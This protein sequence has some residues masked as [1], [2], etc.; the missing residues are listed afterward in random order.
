[1]FTP[2][3]R[4]RDPFDDFIE[5]LVLENPDVALLLVESAACAV[6]GACEAMDAAVALDPDEHPIARGAAAVSLLVPVFPSLGRVAS[7]ILRHADDAPNLGRVADDL[8]ISQSADVMRGG[9]GH[10]Y[11]VE[12]LPGGAGP[13]VFAGHGEYRLLSGDVE[14]P[15]GTSLTFWSEHGRGIRDSVGQAIERGE[16]PDGFHEGAV[17]YLPGARIPDYTLTSPRGLTVYE[18]STTVEDATRISDLIRPGMGNC[19][20][21]ACRR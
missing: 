9:S 11:A 16:V 15:E 2:V 18:N 4:P 13:Q 6:P 8:L 1:M 14:I 12:V 17:T 5:E 21:A 3:P 7:R 20:W 19:Q 10:G